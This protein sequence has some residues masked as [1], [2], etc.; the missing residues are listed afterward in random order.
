MSRRQKRNKTLNRVAL[1][2]RS[3]QLTPLGEIH[4]VQAQVDSCI[5]YCREHGY[6]IPRD[7][8]STEVQ[9]VSAGSDRPALKHLGEAIHQ[10]S[11]AI[12]AVSSF[13]RFTQDPTQSAFLVEEFKLAGVTIATSEHSDTYEPL[14]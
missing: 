13:D 12:L 1:Y 10:G 6:I 7:Q 4:T 8:G 14:A 2:A 9:T 5:A 3:S 11:V